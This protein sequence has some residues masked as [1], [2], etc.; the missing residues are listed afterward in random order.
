MKPDP[1]FNLI[2]RA[3]ELG[4]GFARELVDF[5]KEVEARLL[6]D[7]TPAKQLL[8]R[9]TIEVYNLHERG[10][11]IA[12]FHQ[13]QRVANINGKSVPNKPKRV[14]GLGLT[15]R[16]AIESLADGLVSEKVIS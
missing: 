3:E 10:E 7:R 2:K 4:S 13:E 6:L 5:A 16:A 1:E 14:N 9:G 15:P 12:E 11:F 8:T